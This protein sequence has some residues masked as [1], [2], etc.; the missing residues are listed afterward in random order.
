MTRAGGTRWRTTVARGLVVVG[1][2]AF[3]LAST[4]YLTRPGFTPVRLV[5]LLGLGALAVI[6]S[7]G[8]L[9]G[10][11]RLVALAAAALFLLGFWQAVLWFLLWGQVGVLVIAFVLDDSHRT[12]A[13]GD[14]TGHA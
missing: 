14:G 4:W 10:R 3:L 7:L 6:G 1:T 5:L 8:V 11:D 12:R 13:S 9:R 2:L